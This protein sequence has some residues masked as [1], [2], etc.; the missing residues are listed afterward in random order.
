VAAEARLAALRQLAD[1]ADDPAL[2]AA[3]A[4]VQE[5]ATALQDEARHLVAL[6]AQGDGLDEAA[7]RAEAIGIDPDQLAARLQIL[8][9]EA[10]DLGT[11]REL[12]SA[13]LARA[14][15][16]LETLRK[17]Q[18]AAGAA[19]AAGQ[20]LAEAGTAAESYARLHVARVLLRA[21]IDRF[22]RSQQGPLL[23]AASRNFAALTL[24]RY[25][26]LGVDEDA[27]GK[28]LLVAAQA[29]GAECPVNAL[30]EG[31]RDQL[32]LAL[33]VAA[34]EQHALAVE[35]LPFVADDLLVHFDDE[36]T[37]CRAGSSRS[38]W[39][40]HAGHPVHASRP[41]RPHGGTPR[42]RRDRRSAAGVAACSPK[43]APIREV[44]RGTGR[45]PGARVL[46]RSS[47]DQRGFLNWGGLGP[48]ENE[49]SP[50][51]PFFFFLFNEVKLSAPAHAKGLE[52]PGD[53]NGRS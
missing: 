3:I 12:L 29:D 28:L 27:G 38:A 2:T 22:R 10:A 4:R 53:I 37:Q 32:F 42:L 14:E 11:K 15:A 34:V 6:A 51:P 19:Q 35:P 30:S 40:Q 7:L 25:A 17:G 31:T 50:G 43:A 16:S 8:G 47:L 18:D 39:P 26:R 1:A 36:R 5:R 13:T 46:K 45:G 23:Q 52:G 20:A 21:G 9:E 49:F 44:K 48:G 24:G 33:R 41:H